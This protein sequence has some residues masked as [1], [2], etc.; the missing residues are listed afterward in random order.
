ME[1]YNP[2]TLEKTTRAVLIQAFYRE[3]TAGRGPVYMDCGSI[4]PELWQRWEKTG[5][6]F[7]N[8][9]KAAGIDYEKGKVYLVPALHCFLGGIVVDE[10]GRTK[11]HG[12]LAAGEATTGIHGAVR[13]G[14]SAFAE[15][16]VFGKR[17]GRQAALYAR[18]R[19]SENSG[20]ITSF[21]EELLNRGHESGPNSL[22]RQL[23]AMKQTADGTIGVI[24]NASDLQLGRDFFKETYDQ[25]LQYRAP[26]PEE[27]DCK[28]TLRNLSL[29]G[30]LSAQAA[31]A[32]E[33]TRGGHIRDDFPE[34]DPA[35]LVNFI[36]NV[37]HPD[38]C[39]REFIKFKEKD[40]MPY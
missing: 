39:F 5:H 16:F 8:F 14:G 38:G 36:F 25:I 19:E 33:E 28:I 3:M 11:I 35:F 32:R 13:L 1:K 17:A 12:L 30:L 26:T 40:L 20:D 7:L 4:L 9:I 23:Q 27:L 10:W 24:R 18:D 22:N 29:T 31:L 6:P 21:L 2:E 15:C 37:D 34:E